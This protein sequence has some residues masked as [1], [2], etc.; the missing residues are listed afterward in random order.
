MSQFWSVMRSRVVP[1]LSGSVAAVLLLPVTAFAGGFSGPNVVHHP[2][3]TGSGGYGLA[4]FLG[5]VAVA[6]LS[7]VIVSRAG[8]ERKRATRPAKSVRHKPA[9][10]AS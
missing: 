2:A 1:I 10:I 9:G 8:A 3:A 4:I 5:V 6:L 7:F